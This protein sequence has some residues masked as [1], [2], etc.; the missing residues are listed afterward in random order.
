MKLLAASS[1]MEPMERYVHT[2]TA[3]FVRRD[4]TAIFMGGS[5]SMIII[6][7]LTIQCHHFHTLSHIFI[8]RTT[9]TSASQLSSN[10]SIMQA[11]VPMLTILFQSSS[12]AKD[13]R[14]T[15]RTITPSGISCTTQIIPRVCGGKTRRNSMQPSRTTRASASG[16]TFVRPILLAPLHLLAATLRRLSLP[17]IRSGKRRK[18]IG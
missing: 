6:H 2:T 4:T 10:W 11:S 1:A 15:L 18:D 7:S 8:T 9:R 16:R 13:R 14:K 17:T 3:R 12:C 5:D